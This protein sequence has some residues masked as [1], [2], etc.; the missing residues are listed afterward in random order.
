M[1]RNP[2]ARARAPNLDGFEA[3]LPAIN[4][5]PPDSTAIGNVHF[6]YQV[7]ALGP[8]DPAEALAI[9]PEPDTVGWQKQRALVDLPIV[10]AAVVK[11]ERARAWH[12]VEAAI[13]DIKRAI[14]QPD[15]TLGIRAVHPTGP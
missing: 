3:R 6:L 9:I 2:M 1:R 8:D 11:A 5:A 13:A 10:I 14:E 12:F 7:P 4:G 15:R